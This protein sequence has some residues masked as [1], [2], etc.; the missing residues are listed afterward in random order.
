MTVRI[1]RIYDPAAEHD[2]TRVLVDRIWPR[3]LRKADAAVDR[4]PRE[5]APSKE[6]RQWFGHEPARF[7]TFA[8]RYRAELDQRPEV[9]GELAELAAQ[10]DVTLLYAA[11]DPDCNHARV[12]ADYLRESRVAEPGAAGRD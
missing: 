9:V 5:I 7:K 1:K 6:L 4:W 11:R 12:L 3:G 2:G 8:A 10:G